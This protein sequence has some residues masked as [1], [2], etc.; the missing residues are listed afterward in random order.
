MRAIKKKKKGEREK[1]KKEAKLGR[2]KMDRL[3]VCIVKKGN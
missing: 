3:S 1:E 2:A